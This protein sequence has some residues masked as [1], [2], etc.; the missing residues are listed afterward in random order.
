ME[1]LDRLISRELSHEGVQC[2]AIRRKGVSRNAVPLEERAKR[3]M[4]KIEKNWF[5]GDKRLYAIFFRVQVL[6]YCHVIFIDIIDFST[7][8][9]NILN[10]NA[11]S[12]FN[13]I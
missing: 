3:A 6:G 11:A 2:E 12:S 10:L 1:R 5:L 9:E 13:V 8:D 4:D 7:G